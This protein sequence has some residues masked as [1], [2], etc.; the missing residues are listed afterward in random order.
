V[1]PLGTPPNGSYYFCNLSSRVYRLGI[2]AI[3]S[4]LAANMQWLPTR[5]SNIPRWSA[6]PAASQK[7]AAPGCGIRVSP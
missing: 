5:W 7:A 1:E 3:L 2:G 6:Q 4:A